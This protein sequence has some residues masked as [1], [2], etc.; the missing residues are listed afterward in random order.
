MAKFFLCLFLIIALCGCTSTKTVMSRVNA[1]YIGRD[2]DEFVLKH[3]IPGE[4]YEMK[5]GDTIYNWTSEVYSVRTP[6][7]TSLN[8]YKSSLTGQYYG[9]AIT[10]GGYTTEYFCKL[11]IQVS[12][13]GKI[14]SIRALKDTWGKWAMS[15]CSEC[16]KEELTQKTVASNP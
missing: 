16:F 9:T 4:K 5:N 3:G 7:T 8:G 10:H 6:A 11:R 1:Q 14:V 2:F 13:D 12:A 15:R